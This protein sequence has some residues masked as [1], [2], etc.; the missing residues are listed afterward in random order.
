M[1]YFPCLFRVKQT[2]DQ[3]VRLQNDMYEMSKPLA[4]YADDADLDS[5]LKDQDR[6]GDPMLEY[7][8]NK[9][10]EQSKN[11]RIHITTFFPISFDFP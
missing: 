10:K 11:K 9:K 5:Y 1:N 8:Q 2:E 4:R 6:E 7:L 3:Q